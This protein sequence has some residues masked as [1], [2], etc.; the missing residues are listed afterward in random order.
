MTRDR[1]QGAIAQLGSPNP[2]RGPP[3][4]PRSRKRG[5]RQLR[6]FGPDRW[7]ILAHILAVTRTAFEGTL[8]SRYP[9]VGS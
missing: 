9:G 4:F 8:T 3:P 7:R 1:R 2:R 5:L 6:T